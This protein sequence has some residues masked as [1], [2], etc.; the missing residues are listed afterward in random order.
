MEVE[1]KVIVVSCVVG[2]LG[3][4]SAVT[5]FAA[6]FKRIKVFLHSIISYVEGGFG[7]FVFL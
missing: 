4:L 3:L 1:R 7:L 5:A 2:F 6:E